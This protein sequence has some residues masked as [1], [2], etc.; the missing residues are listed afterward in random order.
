ML[1]IFRTAIEYC[2]LATYGTSDVFSLN[3]VAIAY[4]QRMGLV[5]FF[6][7]NT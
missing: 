2:I 4:W 7:L 5:T 1:K 3:Y 6:S